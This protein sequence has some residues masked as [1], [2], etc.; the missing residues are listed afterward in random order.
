VY[1]F[2]AATG[3]DGIHGAAFASK[4]ISEDS[5]NDLPS[6]Q[7]GDPFWEKLILEASMELLDTDSVVG[8][9]DMGAAGIT[10]ST[11]EMAAK[12]GTGMKVQLDKVPMRQ[13]DMKG[14]EI[15]L[16]E[17]QERMLVILHKGKE[18]RAIDIFKKWDLT[19]A[20]IG[21]VTDTGRVEYYM[22]DVL[23]ADIPAESLA[24]GGGA[25]VYAR[26][27]AEPAY[28]AE[29]K[30]FDINS[31]SDVKGDL[32]DVITFLIQLPN[33]ASKQWIYNQYDSM[34]GTVNQ[35]TNRPSDAAVVMVKG[36]NKSLALTV[37]CN[38][39]YVWADPE[40]GCAIAVAEAARNI[41]C[42]GGVP[43]GVTNCLNFGNPYD[44][45]VYYQFKNSIDGMGRACRKFET[46]VTGGNVSFYNQSTDG[47]AVYPTP[48]IGMVGI[49]EKP[50]HIMTLDFKNEGDLI[51]L[52]GENHNDIA[53][54]QYLAKY[55][56][57]N[58]SP[59]PYFDL[60]KEYNLQQ[61]TYNL[62]TNNH[63]Q[64]CHDLSE[65]GLFVALFE[66]AKHRGLGFEITTDKNFRTDAFLFGEAQSRIVVSIKPEN[67]ANF[68]NELQKSGTPFRN[69]GTVK[70]SDMVIDGTLA[71]SLKDY[72][73]LYD[74]AIGNVIEGN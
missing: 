28:I 50:E 49:I 47:E 67:K 59:A 9:Q 5:I 1:I 32:K 43:S 17:S 62:I 38:S 29:N 34:V 46:P 13:A 3:K 73:T 64:S 18:K 19:Y 54:S 72:E 66:S 42:S 68:E 2:G 40:V 51:Y 56:N 11:A 30:K 25:P 41:V 4:D 26:E 52:L 7:V 27:W 10:C 24:L 33:I 12:S 60:D 65:G 35:S 53:S 44:K 61:V 15:L 48:T 71:G 74:N 14:W 39:R 70:G 45:G 16:S 21:E 6:V 37:D 55:R 36:T 57:V 69:I 8:M 22:N 20:C 23:E 63:L 58:N 31:V